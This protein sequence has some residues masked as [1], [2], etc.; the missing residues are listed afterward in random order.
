MLTETLYDNFIYD[1]V[2]E[3]PSSVGDRRSGWRDDVER[4]GSRQGLRAGEVTSGRLV[5]ARLP[6]ITASLFH[7]GRP[8]HSDILW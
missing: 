1:F 6:S 3:G 4:D 7:T 8:R 5:H 2:L